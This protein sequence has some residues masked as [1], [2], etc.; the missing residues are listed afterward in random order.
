MPFQ[1]SAATP[2]RAVTPAAFVRGVVAAYARYGRDPTDALNKAQVPA[3]LVKSADARVTAAQF[4]ELAGHAMRE[5]DDE[6]LGWF[7]RPLPWGT[8][9]MLC[10]AS[11]TAP[12][13]EIALR[14]WCRHHRI[15]TEDVLFELTVGEETAAISIREQR[16]LGPFREFCLVTLLRYVLGFSCWAV[17]SAIAL[18]AAE[19]PLPEPRHVSVYPTI[20]CKTLGFNAERASMSFDKRY[21]SLPLKRGAEDLD[22]ML[23]GALRLTVL[24][25]RRDRLLVERIRRVLRGA[26][27]RILR[28]EDVASELALSTR[29][30]HRRLREETTSLRELK[31]EAKRELAT[32]E[33]ARGRAPIKRIAEL[34]GFRNEK[35]FSRAFRSW[36]GSSPRDFRDKHR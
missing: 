25:Y 16:D 8:Y 17:D 26:R 36:T 6:A 30:M 1:T 29:T 3:S 12:N 22:N 11:I 2:R 13:L 24:P 19:F 28:A 21:L 7:S 34:A 20:F 18:R 15:L 14:R 5:L 9:G 23:K 31:E 10:R 4:E 33:L 35:S 27:G 32:R